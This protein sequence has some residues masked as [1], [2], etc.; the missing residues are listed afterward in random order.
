[1]PESLDD[2]EAFGRLARD[3]LAALNLADQLDQGD[4]DQESSADGETDPNASEDEDDSAE[5]QEQA[6]LAQETRADTDDAAEEALEDQE[7]GATDE[8]DL[9]GDDDRGP[10]ETLG[11]SQA[12]GRTPS[13]DSM[14]Q[15]GLRLQGFHHTSFDETVGAEELVRG[16]RARPAARLPR[17]AARGNLQGVGR[18]P[19]QQAAAPALMAQQNRSAGISTWRKAM[20]DRGAPRRAS[21]SIRCSRSPSSRSAT[22][23]SAILSSALASRQFGIDAWDVRLPLQPPAP[24]S[25][26]VRLERCGVKVEILGFTTRAWK[27]GQSR[28]SSGLK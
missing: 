11:R 10:A 4:Q 28:E 9:R 12:Q 5:G 22:R 7:D 14:T 18:S 1:M 2:Q 3:L 6:E 15:S 24:I 27:G 21:S 23:N 25:W 8:F 20:L 26:R 17:Q 19:C 16:R 13:R